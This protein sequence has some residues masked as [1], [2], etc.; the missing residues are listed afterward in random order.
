MPLGMLFGNHSD[1]AS[2]RAQLGRIERKLDVLLDHLG[3][4]HGVEGQNPLNPDAIAQIRDL[5]AR[6]RKIEAIKAY[7]KATGASLVEARN[8]I[9]RGL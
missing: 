4:E 7:R 6:G 9:D 8:A 5:I 1:D 2:L 3:I